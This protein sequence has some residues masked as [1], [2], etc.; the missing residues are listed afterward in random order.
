MNQLAVRKLPLGVYRVFWNDGG[1]SVAAIGQLHDG[2]RWLAPA[3]WT[4]SALP[5]VVVC[6]PLWWRRVDR[7]LFLIEA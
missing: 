7:V 2:T 4:A 6:S 5:G 3:N 1:S